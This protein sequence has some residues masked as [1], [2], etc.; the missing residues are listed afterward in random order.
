MYFIIISNNDRIPSREVCLPVSSGQAPQCEIMLIWRGI[1][2]NRAVFI[3]IANCFL[4]GFFFVFEC[5]LIVLI[6]RIV[7]MSV[8]LQQKIRWSSMAVTLKL[9]SDASS[10]TREFY[11]TI[12]GRGAFKMR[13][14]FKSPFAGV[15]QNKLTTEK[16][17]RLGCSENQRMTYSQI[18]SGSSCVNSDIHR[19]TFAGRCSTSAILRELLSN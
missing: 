1:S 15:S 16:P 13:R 18:E 8:G 11:F 6:V 2:Q 10:M 7:M 9:S 4:F 3:F 19:F 17:F 14:G 12:L 5:R